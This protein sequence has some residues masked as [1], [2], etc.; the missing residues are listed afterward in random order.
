VRIG[1]QQY[2]QQKIDDCVNYEERSGDDG[3]LRKRAAF[4]RV[5][6]PRS[7]DGLRPCRPGP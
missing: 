5:R 6:R 7:T 4:R 1:Q 2:A 3:S